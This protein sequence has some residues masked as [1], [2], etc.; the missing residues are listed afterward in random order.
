MTLP[1]SK[2]P[3]IRLR[4]KGREGEKVPVGFAWRN[5]GTHI[6]DRSDKEDHK[7]IEFLRNANLCE[8][9]ELCKEQGNTYWYRF[10]D[11]QEQAEKKINNS[12]QVADAMVAVRN[13][14]KWSGPENKD[15]AVQDWDKFRLLGYICLKKSVDDGNKK[16]PL[17]AI[18]ETVQENPGKVLS[19]LND[20]KGKYEKLI[21][22]ALKY[23][24]LTKQGFNM[25]FGGEKLGNQKALLHK[26]SANTKDGRTLYNALKEEVKLKMQK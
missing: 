16:E 22:D 18:L 4:A 14:V 7:T 15:I 13:I 26:I 8:G 5:Q 10:V 23:K 12:M 19:V 6:F 25:V 3:P 17:G 1:E 2:F 9:S 20:G 11:P 21:V 24:V